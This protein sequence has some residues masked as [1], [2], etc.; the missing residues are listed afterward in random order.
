[1]SIINL[2]H[3]AS[4]AKRWE[5]RMHADAA[6]LIATLGEAAY[7]TAADR[8]WREDMGLL[9]SRD[10]GH[11]SRVTL[12]IGRR[13]ALGEAGAKAPAAARPAARHG[14]AEAA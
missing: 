8:A 10:A 13:L 5:A 7:A 12:E 4:H 14:F 1:M 9:P 3:W 6:D 11:W 2:L